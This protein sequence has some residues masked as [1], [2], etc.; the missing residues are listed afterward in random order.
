[1]TPS[2]QFDS[3]RFKAA[4]HY[5]CA[6]C[7]PRELGRVKLHKILYY[8][9]MLHFVQTGEP[10]TG[11]DYLKQQFGP[12]ARRLGLA[13]KQLQSA[14]KL[15]VEESDY[16]GFKKT[17][18]VSLTNPDVG[19]LSQSQVELLD[20]VIDGVCKQ[21]AKEISELSHAAPWQ[22]VNIGEEIPYYTAFLLFPSETTDE[23]VAWGETAVRELGLAS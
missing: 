16:Y 14:G 18:F 20:D 6:R 1:M 10:L 5:A 8:A 15:R 13:L 4:V 21:T 17:D 22:M 19:S 7:S 23:D 12:T 3:A 9:D 11:D 2:N